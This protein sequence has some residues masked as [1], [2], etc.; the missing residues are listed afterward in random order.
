MRVEEI[1]RLLA[2]FYEGNTSEKQEEILK[3][4]FETQNVPEHLEKDKRLFLC[5]HKRRDVPVEIPAGLED[6]LSRMIDMKEQEEIHFFRK[7]K[8]KRNWRWVGGIATSIVLLL[9]L[10][11]NISNISDSMEKP[12]ETFTEPE[13]AY[14]VLQATLMEVSM[15]LNYGIDEMMDAPKDIRRTNREIKKDLQLQ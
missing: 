7:N 10:G 14:E 1:E 4:Y 12:Q 13:V 8:S 2:D 6:K 15:G 11:Y 9:G 5:F 3:K